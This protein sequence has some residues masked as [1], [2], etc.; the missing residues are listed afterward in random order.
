MSVQC[1]GGGAAD[2]VSLQMCAIPHW[3][4]GVAKRSQLAA[5]FG[6]DLLVASWC[7]NWWKGCDGAYVCMSVQCTGGGA[8]GAVALQMCGDVCRCVQPAPAKSLFGRI[9]DTEGFAMDS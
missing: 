9:G 1:A 8:A 4:R 7:G 6:S 2:A 5:T 3:F